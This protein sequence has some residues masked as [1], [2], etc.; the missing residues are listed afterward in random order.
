MKTKYQVSPSSIEWL[1][2]D[3]SHIADYF[4][5]LAFANL[6]QVIEMRIFDLMN[7]NR[8]NAVR[9]EEIITALYLYLNSNEEADKAMYDGSMSQ[10]FE[11]AEWRKEHKKKENITVGDLILSENINLKAI[12]HLYDSICKKFYK[13]SEYNWRE[14]R[15]RDYVHYEAC[16]CK[17]RHGGT[18]N[19]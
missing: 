3:N 10:Y 13:S 16:M 19:E 14:Y 8:I 2:S 6:G 12:Q 15:Y 5:G 18:T 11:F 4:S 17:A 1:E 9:A 7:M